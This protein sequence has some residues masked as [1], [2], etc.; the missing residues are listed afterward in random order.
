[1]ISLLQVGSAVGVGCNYLK[2]RVTK[3]DDE[4]RIRVTEIIEGGFKD[5]GFDVY[6]VRS[7]MREKD[8][9]SSIIRSTIEYEI[10]GDKLADVASQLTTKPIELMAETIGKYLSQIKKD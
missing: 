3:I 10:N 2:E 4:K 1:M 6:R 9:K 8:D 7:E 5:V